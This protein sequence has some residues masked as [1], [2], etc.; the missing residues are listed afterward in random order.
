MQQVEVA[1]APMGGCEAE[2][3]NEGKQ[4]QENDQGAPIDVLH[5]TLPGLLVALLPLRGVRRNQR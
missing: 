3:G 4:R 1:P 5:E 2:P